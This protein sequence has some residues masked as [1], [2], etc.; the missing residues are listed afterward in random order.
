MVSTV[1]FILAGDIRDCGEANSPRNCTSGELHQKLM[2]KI[3]LINTKSVAK[4]SSNTLL[5]Q[6]FFGLLKI[7]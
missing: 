5:T 2:L 7:F 6:F 4:N 3:V 1:G